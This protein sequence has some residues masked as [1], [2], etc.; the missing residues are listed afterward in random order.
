[1]VSFGLAA[2]LVVARNFSEDGMADD[3]YYKPEVYLKRI[4]ANINTIRKLTVEILGA[5]RE[6]ESEIPE[7]MR[8]FMMYF[9]DVHDI[10]NMYH[11]Q[12]QTAPDYVDS[13]IRRCDDRYRQILNDLHLDGGAFDKVRREMAKDPENRWDHTRQLVK[14]K[15][16]HDEARTGKGINGHGDEGRRQQGEPGRSLADGGRDAGGPA[17]AAEE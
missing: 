6:A 16:T 9:H 13:E 17:K 5:L 15:E 14:P 11:E 10:R 1:M 8:R 2:S 3:D 7:K 12:G 4:D